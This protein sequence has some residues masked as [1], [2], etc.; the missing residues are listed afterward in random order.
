MWQDGIKRVFFC[1]PQTFWNDVKNGVWLQ[2][3]GLL[4]LPRAKTRQCVLYIAALW[5]PAALNCRSYCSCCWSAQA[6]TQS[7]VAPGHNN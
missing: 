6:A 4:P 1:T 3:M 5:P 7:F 2:N